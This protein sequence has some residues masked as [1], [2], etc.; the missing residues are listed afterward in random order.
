MGAGLELFGRRKDGTEFPIDVSLRPVL[1]EG[2]MQT[3]AAVRDITVLR[4]AEQERARQAEQLRLQSDLLALAHD[5][6][7][8]RDPQSCIVFW[9]RGAEELYGWTAPEAKGHVT[10]TL[11]KT[12]LPL[13]LAAVDEQLTCHGSWEGELLHTRRDGRSVLV[14]SRQ[15][16]VRNAQGQPTAILEIN[17]D[18]T[19]RRRLEQIQQAT[20]AATAAHLT[21]LQQ[22]LD[23][24]PSSVYLVRGPRSVWCWPIKRQPVSGELP[25]A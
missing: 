9:N 5:A 16:L 24:L 15:V 8:V 22:V 14:E 19:E 17:R 2:A 25:G 6:I 21:F 1:V 10:H 3:I 7:L 20:H 13:G 4:R 11:L 12:R 23:T 18:I